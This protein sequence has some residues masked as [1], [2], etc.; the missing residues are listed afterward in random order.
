[1]IA[2]KVLSSTVIKPSPIEKCRLLI[3]GLNDS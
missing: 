2:M 3:Y 1:L